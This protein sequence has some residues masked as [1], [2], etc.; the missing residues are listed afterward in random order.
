MYDTVRAKINTFMSVEI[1]HVIVKSSM[2]RFIINVDDH[3]RTRSLFIIKNIDN[4]IHQRLKDVMYEKYR[5]YNKH[6]DGN[7]INDRI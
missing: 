6:N 3:Y 2:F 1:R 7:R 4:D 5:E